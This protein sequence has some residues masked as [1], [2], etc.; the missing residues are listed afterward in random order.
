MT[1]ETLEQ[2]HTDYVTGIWRKVND[3]EDLQVRVMKH[4]ISCR[5]ADIRRNGGNGMLA[6]CNRYTKLYQQTNEL[7]MLCEY[8]DEINMLSNLVK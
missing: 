1:D 5:I 4:R 7:D 8:Y 2:M 6:L 3:W